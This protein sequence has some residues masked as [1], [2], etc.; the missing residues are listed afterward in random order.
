MTNNHRI[1]ARIGQLSHTDLA[2]K[3]T[4]VPSMAVL[5]CYSELW[6]VHQQVHRLR[7]LYRGRSNNYHHVSQALRTEFRFKGFN[8]VVA[9]FEGGVHL[10]IA[11]ENFH[12]RVF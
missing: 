8:K 1:G 11:G 7:E 5:R 9:L 6:I 4:V 3:G 10:P 2:G 12:R